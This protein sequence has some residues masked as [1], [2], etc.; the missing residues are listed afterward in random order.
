M[1]KKKQYDYQRIDRRTAQDDWYL[2]RRREIVSAN[3]TVQKKSEGGGIEMSS[4]GDAHEQQADAIAQKVVNGGDVNLSNILPVTTTVQTK[5]EGE[6]LTTSPEFANELNS[7]KG[8]GQP[9]DDSTRTEMESKMR[10]DFSGVKIH[11]G[12]A[13]SSLNRQVNAQAFTEGSDIYFNEGKYNPES[14]QG[15]ELLAHELVHTVQQGNGVSRKVFRQP[16]SEDDIKSVKSQLEFTLFGISQEKR[17]GILRQL[18]KYPFDDVKKAWLSELNGYLKAFTK[19]FRHSADFRVF[20][21]TISATFE[22]LEVGTRISRVQ[23]LIRKKIFPDEALIIFYLIQGM[24]VDDL[25]KA[26]GFDDEASFEKNYHRFKLALSSDD[27][28]LLVSAKEYQLSK[29]RRTANQTS[30]KIDEV[31]DKIYEL[32]G[33]KAVDSSET[34]KKAEK[35]RKNVNK[36]VK[37]ILSADETSADHQNDPVKSIEAYRILKTLNG[38]ELIDFGAKYPDLFTNIIDNLPVEF[39]NS[40][41]YGL[42]KVEHN[43]LSQNP[44]YK[45]KTIVDEHISSYH[46]LHTITKPYRFLFN[47]PIAFAD[48]LV[49]FGQVKKDEKELQKDYLF[50]HRR[51]KIENVAADHVSQTDNAMLYLSAGVPDGFVSDDEK[52]IFDAELQEIFNI[53]KNR[54]GIFLESSEWIMKPG[55][56]EINTEYVFSVLAGVLHDRLKDAAQLKDDTGNLYKGD[57]DLIESESGL[58]RLL[59]ASP[60]PSK[61]PLQKKELVDQLNEDDGM[62]EVFIEDSG[63]YQMISDPALW[64]ATADANSE[65]SGV[66]SIAISGG[67][68]EKIARYIDNNITKRD[69]KNTDKDEN[70]T[71]TESLGFINGSFKPQSQAWTYGNSTQPE[72]HG[73]EIG[74]DVLLKMLTEAYPDKKN[75][76][77]KKS[78]IGL[79]LFAIMHRKKAGKVVRAY[80][81][82]NEGYKRPDKK[83]NRVKKAALN[84]IDL[85]AVQHG[86]GDQI[87]GFEFGDG[88]KSADNHAFLNFSVNEKTGEAS[89][90]SPNMPIKAMN[91]Q[92]PDMLFTS[93]KGLFGN[94]SATLKW[95]TKNDSFEGSTNMHFDVLELN[96][97]HYISKDMVF[98]LGKIRFENLTISSNKPLANQAQMNNWSTL[99]NNTMGFIQTVLALMMDGLQ[100]TS[101]RFVPEL[102]KDIID[103]NQANKTSANPEK[104]L[105]DLLLQKL[106]ENEELTINFDSLN[107]EDMMTN[108]YGLIKSL[109]TGASQMS[110]KEQ[111]AGDEREVMFGFKGDNLAIGDLNMSGNAIKALGSDTFNLGMYFGESTPKNGNRDLSTLQS[112]SNSSA[113]NKDQPL[114][115][116]KKLTFSLSGMTGE[117][118]SLIGYDMAHLPFKGIDGVIEMIDEKTDQNNAFIAPKMIITLNSVTDVNFFDFPFPADMSMRIIGGPDAH[119]KGNITSGK[120]E[121]TLNSESDQLVNGLDPQEIKISNLLIPTLTGDNF[122][123]F[124]QGMETKVGKG[125]TVQNVLLTDFVM[126][127]DPVNKDQWDFHSMNLGMGAVSMEGI[128]ITTTSGLV[129]NLKQFN[130]GT[131]NF[132]LA[133]TQS[134]NGNDVTETNKFS[135]S[136]T[137]IVAQGDFQYNGQPDIYDPSKT[138]LKLNGEIDINN[139]DLAGYTQTTTLNDEVTKSEMGFSGSFDFIKLPSLNVTSEKLHI[140]AP[141]VTDNPIMLSGVKAD[142]MVQYNEFGDPI[143]F[144][145]KSL[146]ITST[147]TNGLKVTNVKTGLNLIDLPQRKPSVISGFYINN[148]TMQ[149]RP[150]TQTEILYMQRDR[151]KNKEQMPDYTTT[152]DFVHEKEGD[153]KL[154][155]ASSSFP[156]GMKLAIGEHITAEMTRASSKDVWFEFITTD[157][158]KYSITDLDT[159]GLIVKKDEKSIFKGDI[160]TQKIGGSYK[161]ELIGSGD[162]ARRRTT[163]KTTVNIPSVSITKLLMES[164]ETSL[165]IP[166]DANPGSII[167]S[168]T[169]TV[170]VVILS[171]SIKENREAE[172][173][174]AAAKEAH[175]GKTYYTEADKLKAEQE[176]NQKA[177]SKIDI[178]VEQLD[179]EKIRAFGL[180]YHSRHAT[181]I[182]TDSEYTPEEKISVFDFKLLSDQSAVINNLTMTN[183]YINLPADSDVSMTFGGKLGIGGKK[184][185]FGNIIPGIDIGVSEFASEVIQ[186]QMLIIPLKDAPAMDFINKRNRTKISGTGKIS[187]EQLTFEGDSDGN[188]V[189]RVAKPVLDWIK[190]DPTIDWDKIDFDRSFELET[191]Q[192]YISVGIPFFEKAE[193]PIFTADEF[194]VTQTM[195]EVDGK[196]TPQKEFKLVHP[197]I[198]RLHV[199]GD[200]WKEG[201]KPGAASVGLILSGEVTGDLILREGKA[202]LGKNY[203]EHDIQDAWI[204]SGDGEIII[205]SG[206]FYT[207]GIHELKEKISPQKDPDNTSANN[208]EKQNGKSV[209][210]T[211]KQNPNPF[212]FLDF[213]TGFAII[214]LFGDPFILPIE[215]ITHDG[216]QEGGFIQLDIFSRLVGIYLSSKTWGRPSTILFHLHADEDDGTYQLETLFGNNVMELLPD[217]SNNLFY[218]EGREY[219]RLSALAQAFANAES[220][221]TSD[222]FFGFSSSTQNQLSK[223]IHQENNPMNPTI[224]V[225]LNID[226]KGSTSEERGMLGIFS[227]E[228]AIKTTASVHFG[229]DRFTAS[230]NSL[231]EGERK[232]NP[233]VDLGSVDLPAFRYP[234]TTKDQKSGLE[235]VTGV[236]SGDNITLGAAHMEMD[237]AK[238]NDLDPGMTVSASNIS[239]QGFTLSMKKKK[240]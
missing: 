155:F 154:G 197:V 106:S 113:L 224:N 205:E 112:L 189:L 206:T 141:E 122:S 18:S 179:I 111:L 39:L 165:E 29:E 114:S 157:E 186:T 146:N 30:V 187:V 2:Q 100:V 10:T 151:E 17:L 123:V 139:K 209:S 127:P 51:K 64:T 88:T 53:I 190:R 19:S 228:T 216:I 28:G 137:G 82:Y 68:G 203:E 27:S 159:N 78:L 148:L 170:S 134:V 173:R 25:Q 131:M 65:L 98:T 67:F 33:I 202:D 70:Q 143:L 156:E 198:D 213:A 220:Q 142:V 89:F 48:A 22:A 57:K 34:G 172:A 136:G 94:L 217:V 214:H 226:P 204:M 121:I 97:L 85:V 129:T 58:D 66:L 14:N 43:E 128:G 222:D 7:S 38:E 126:R 71:I 184:D 164:D 212:G 24:Q 229:Q 124:T 167:D 163:I 20:P 194:V 95:P 235:S 168:I 221:P 193:K 32:L 225:N 233:I 74:R 211:T 16:V 11:T 44:L 79:A 59:I 91:M 117:G 4:P 133:M 73:G 87:F 175:K 90:T 6:A 219:V 130:A 9:L 84:N 63:I 77:E 1:S 110:F 56:D 234:M 119:L 182:K 96:D 180:K 26:F 109:K 178:N 35:K 62:L 8:S 218:V 195:Q 120:I 101:Q 13:A 210:G 192:H 3:N 208:Q 69:E 171:P 200:L 238:V 54:P 144:Q 61:D 147:E 160:D 99:F 153:N 107:V 135:Y 31:A 191:D 60:M 236:V 50:A 83:S 105:N 12:S 102:S 150:F 80:R 5:S 104:A 86:M 166:E 230:E 138:P 227:N 37:K 199:Y 15:K 52:I 174:S 188:Y 145:V 47:N 239:I 169:G 176:E 132:N 223:W 75:K 231:H 115:K 81:Y 42:Q 116:L 76:F 40:P 45:D 140:I 207:P 149:T 125:G 36:K 103:K 185:E 158:F 92:Y 161:T 49:K 181:V 118:L 201:K 177:K 108:G 21:L 232:M 41:E 72:V 23:S 55:T 196:M 183:F 240:K 162:D 237:P 215:N 93:G 152:F 46:H